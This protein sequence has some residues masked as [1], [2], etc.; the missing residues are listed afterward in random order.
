MM[1]GMSEMVVWL[2]TQIEARKATAEAATDG[3][4]IV[5]TNP[6]DRDSITI[7]GGPEGREHVFYDPLGVDEAGRDFAHVALNDPRDTIARCEAE[8]AILDLH[9][10][11]HECRTCLRQMDTEDHEGDRIEYLA[12]EPS[13]CPS[14]RLLASGYR[15]RDGWKDE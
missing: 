9:S 3:P 12:M 8:L 11:K 15:N 2:R 14:L 4:W 7:L 13:P 5:V 6:E 10:D 1:D